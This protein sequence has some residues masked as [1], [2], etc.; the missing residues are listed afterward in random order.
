MKL[1]KRP[2]INIVTNHLIDYP[3]PI[4]FN[5]WYNFGLL[6]GIQLLTGIFLIEKINS[7]EITK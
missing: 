3:T 4:N 1:L 7:Y 2:L 5:Y 6:S